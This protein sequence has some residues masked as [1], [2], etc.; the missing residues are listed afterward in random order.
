[1]IS[2]EVLSLYYDTRYHDASVYDRSD[3]IIL[4]YYNHNHNDNPTDR[5][6]YHSNYEEDL[7]SID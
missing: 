6:S 3:D 1:M 7:L 2:S 5:I 4:T